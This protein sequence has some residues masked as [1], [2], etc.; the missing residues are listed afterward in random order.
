MAVLKGVALLA[1]PTVAFA[2][3]SVSATAPVSV[4]IL[5]PVTLEATQALA[6]GAVTKPSGT[7][8]NTVSLDASGN[9]AI[10]GSGDASHPA[11]VAT[12][13]KFA[14]LGQ[15]GT[16]YSTSQ[17]LSFDQAG[18]GHPSATAPVP[19][20]GTLGVIPASGAQELRFGGAFELSSATPTGSYTGSLSVTVNYN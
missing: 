1:F 20:N 18:L 19:S 14:L 17:T 16:T 2:G 3:G 13:A 5:A 12:A 4:T 11:S 8:G 10:T 7:A 15:A 9:V 6:F